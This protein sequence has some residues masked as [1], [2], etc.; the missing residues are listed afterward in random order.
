MEDELR[1]GRTP[2]RRVQLEG[3]RPTGRV[4]RDQDVRAEVNQT[5]GRD[6]MTTVKEALNKLL[7]LPSLTRSHAQA[8]LIHAHM[9]GLTGSGPSPPHRR[10][11]H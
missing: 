11:F 8:I 9:H 3:T 2:R 10:V 5:H 7:P 6:M 1:V 4:Q